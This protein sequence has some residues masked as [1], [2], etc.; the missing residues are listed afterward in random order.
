MRKA[1]P[2][3]ILSIWIGV[4]V[5]VGFDGNWGILILVAWY[6]LLLVLPFAIFW[7]WKKIKNRKSN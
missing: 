7:A 3:I 5:W 4:G 1:N 2:L 6:I